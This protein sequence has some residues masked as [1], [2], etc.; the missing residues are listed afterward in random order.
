MEPPVVLE[1]GVTTPP[2]TMT[3]PVLIHVPPVATPFCNSV[4]R[5]KLDKLVQ[6]VVSLS[7]PA[8]GAASITMDVVVWN[9]L[10][11]F[12]AGMEYPTI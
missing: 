4:F 7:G 6:S 9:G 8:S 10:Q 12:V 2:G 3:F 5:S 11:P 1:E